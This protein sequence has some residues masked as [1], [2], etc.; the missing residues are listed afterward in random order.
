MYTHKRF[1]SLIRILLIQP[2]RDHLNEICIYDPKR[3]DSNYNF[4]NESNL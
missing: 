3:I 2:Q 4:F 1:V